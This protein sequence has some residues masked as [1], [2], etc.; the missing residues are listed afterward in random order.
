MKTDNELY[1]S[2]FDDCKWQI[3][4]VMDLI[5]SKLERKNNDKQKQFNCYLPKALRVCSALID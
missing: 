1:K 4:A 5:F 2:P 3:L